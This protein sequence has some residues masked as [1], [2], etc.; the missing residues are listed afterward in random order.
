MLP[1]AHQAFGRCV[2]SAASLLFW[3][4][5]DRGPPSTE[6]L[7]SCRALSNTLFPSSRPY[8]VQPCGIDAQ[9]ITVAL[10]LHLILSGEFLQSLPHRSPC[11]RWD[12]LLCSHRP[13]LPATFINHQLGFKGL[14][15][16]PVN[17]ISSMGCS[18]PIALPSYPVH[19]AGLVIWLETVLVFLSIWM[20]ALIY[21]R[22]IKTLSVS[23]IRSE[24]V[25]AIYLF[26]RETLLK[27]R[28]KKKSA[29]YSTVKAVRSYKGRR[30]QM[31][32][33]SH[34]LSPYYSAPINSHNVGSRPLFR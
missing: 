3:S 32:S 2:V 33:A 7:T 26:Q 34:R 14:V 22:H 28:N 31:C 4:S 29:N 6:F 23:L 30:I 25:E 10:S 12:L 11:K 17:D 20:E 5:A 24:V 8:C 1:L 13:M 19:C 21:L 16:G 15:I 18:L 27:K 9:H